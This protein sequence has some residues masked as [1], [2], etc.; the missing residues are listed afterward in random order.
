M[1]VSGVLPRPRDEWESVIHMKCQP[2]L[3]ILASNSDTR[4]QSPLPSLWK[5]APGADRLHA[6]TYVRC[7]ER[8]SVSSHLPAWRHCEPAGPVRVGDNRNRRDRRA[9]RR[10]SWDDIFDKGWSV[11]RLGCGLNS[12]DGSAQRPCPTQ[13]HGP[14][15]FEMLFNIDFLDEAHCHFR[16]SVACLNGAR[17][18]RSLES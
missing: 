6:A 5:M 17:L 13:P 2:L 12:G 4:T 11:L 14:P 9:R 1:A 15:C 18:E 10:M 16:R 7:A 3:R 8:P